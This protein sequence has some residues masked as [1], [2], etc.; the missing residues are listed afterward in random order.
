L[1]LSFLVSL[2]LLEGAARI[3]AGILPGLVVLSA[4]V[5]FH[6]FGHFVLAKWL[7]VPVHKF[8]LGFGPRLFGV[9]LGE[10]DYCVSLLPLGGYVSMA[11]EEKAADGQVTVVDHF[12]GQ[13]WWK[14]AVIALGG[15]GAN[16]L[17]AYVLMVVV[18]LVGV[19]F[20]DYR[21]EIGSVEAGSAAAAL[22]FAPDQRIASIDGRPIS[23]W[24]GFLD[25]VDNSRG[26]AAVEVHDAGG[27]THTV[28]VPEALADS[29]LGSVRVRIEPMVGSVAVGLPAYPAGLREGD[30]VRAVNG[31]PVTIWEDLTRLIHASPGKPVRL[32]VQRGN[33]VFSVTVRP[34]PQ[35]M[36]ERTIGV[37]GI[38]PP[39]IGTYTVTMAPGEA[40]RTAFP[41]VGTLVSQTTRGLWMLVARPKEAKDQMGGPLLIMRMSSQQAERGSADFLFFMAVISVAIMAFNLVPLPVLDGG[42]ILIA[43][44]EGLRRKPLAQGFLTAY[45]RLGVALIGSLLVFILFNDVWREAQRG[46]A[47]SRGDRQT[48]PAAPGR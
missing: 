47:V 13:R 43:L 9:R 19:T 11:K 15:P 7:G 36:G 46:R 39:R 22:G 10:T 28:N 31:Q 24:K 17:A 5:M 25:G 38:S 6:E 29:V 30:R 2:A 32:D 42:H 8:S 41:L 16:L 44:L 45:Q 3:V 1:P 14:R 20:D 4:L 48:S 18:G 37:I 21:A 12:T 34:T 26:T 33:R 23:S 35:Q 27:A 40:L